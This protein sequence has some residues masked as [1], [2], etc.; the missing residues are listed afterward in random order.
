MYQDSLK[1]GEPIDPI[2]EL[3]K[4][5]ESSARLREAMGV[6]GKPEDTELSTLEKLQKL[7][8][9]K[10]GKEG[11]LVELIT[12]LTAAGLLRKPGDEEGGGLKTE[13]SEVRKK[14][15]EMTEEKWRDQFA[16]QQRQILIDALQEKVR[17]LG[18]DNPIYFVPELPLLQIT[19]PECGHSVTYR[20]Y[21][22]IPDIDVPC[23]CGNPNHWFIQYKDF[24]QK[25]D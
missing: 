4:R 20:S 3:A 25:E 19:N 22:E 1:K 24:R 16:G 18:Y 12:T 11:G 9:L 13:L 7:G 6:K 14:L 21:A 17:E 8:M 15:E 5:E 2:E 23:T 10:E